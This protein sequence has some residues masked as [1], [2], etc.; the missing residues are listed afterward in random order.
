MTAPVSTA[1]K[2]RAIASIM[3]GEKAVDV[4]A[5]YGVTPAAIATWRKAIATDEELRLAV[6]TALRAALEGWRPSVRS[7]IVRLVA[8]VEQKL[9]DPEALDAETAIGA[10]RALAGVVGE[11]D[12][13]ARRAG[14]DPP[15]PARKPAGD[16]T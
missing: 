9:A 15:E 3:S 10:I 1:T 16:D 11:A 7:L 4:A 14:I 8:H 5:Q 12:A 13:L 6:S 2:A